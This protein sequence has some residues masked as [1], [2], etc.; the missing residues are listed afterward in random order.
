MVVL[1]PPSFK[2]RPSLTAAIDVQAI[3]FKNLFAASVTV[4]FDST[5]L[6]Y[7]SIFAGSFLTGN[8]TNSVFLGIVPQPPLPAVPNQITVDQAIWGGKTV[9]GT[10]IL[11]S[12]AFTAL[13]AGSSPVTITSYEFRNGM[14]EY[15]LPQ[16]DSGKIIV[17]SIPHASQ[18]LSP[19]DGSMIDT[20]FRA[21]FVWSKSI[22][23]DPGD[24]IK[25]SMCLKNSSSSVRFRDLTDTM[26]L[27][28]MNT[29]KENCEYSWY[30]DATDGID[31]TSSEQTFKFKTPAIS[32]PKEFPGILHMDQNYP[33]PF[34]Q[35]TSIRFA[36]SLS[37]QVSIAIYDITGHEIIRLWNN[38]VNAGYYLIS[39]DG[40]NSKRMIMGSGIYFCKVTAGEY[41]DVK[42]MVLLK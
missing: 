38:T 8:N 21:L 32:F 27:L 28:A 17:N 2:V 6:R 31:T 40:K 10:G 9:S 7:Q 22:D 35:M 14:N 18:L 29:L 41:S 33:N 19:P 24:N 39:W 1:S 34:N 3:G 12:I 16:I 11:F 5:I 26:F 42:K 30:I 23:S 36:V 4:Q 37:T 25:Y 13:R 20:S 15:I